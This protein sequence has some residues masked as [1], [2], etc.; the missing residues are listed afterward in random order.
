MK[1]ALELFNNYYDKFDK[2]LW[3]VYMKY[4]HTMRVVNYCKEIAES[5]N[6]SSE[7]V[8]LA[9]ICGLFHD[10]ARFKQWQEYNT[11]EDKL[12][13]DHG[14]EGY[15]ILKELGIDDEIV[16]LSTK[17][18]NKY[19][20]GDVDYRTKI[21]CNITRDA[22][23]LDI[24]IMQENK[25]NDEEYDVP[26]VVIESLKNK[27]LTHNMIEDK[28]SNTT[29][30]LRCVGF[31]FDMNYKKSFEVLKET[32]IVNKKLDIILSKFDEQDIKDIKNICNEYID[33]R[34]SD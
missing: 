21:F 27:K 26:D 9:M 29:N 22:D 5:L 16:L 3:G 25:C 7:D 30:I 20:V 6:L 14:D 13:F 19:E 33:E 24:M 11:F 15:N 23:K 2:T 10:I 17:Y 8:E 31:I 4:D 28:V 1:E 32:N 12:S 18:H 34:V